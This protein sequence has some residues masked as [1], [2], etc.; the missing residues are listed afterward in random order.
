M[1]VKLL[2][3]HYAS[4]IP[5]IH[6]RIKDARAIVRLEEFSNLKG[7]RNRDLPA[8]IIVLQTNKIPKGSEDYFALE[9]FWVYEWHSLKKKQTKTPW[10]E[11]A[12]ELYG[13]SD[14]CLSVK[15]VNFC[16]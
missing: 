14:R 7:N 5:G 10:S 11:S 8:C 15:L 13:L 3:A 1:A 6:L 16:G 9:N 12:S 4:K 2:A